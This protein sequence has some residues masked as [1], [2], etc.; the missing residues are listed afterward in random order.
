M[1]LLKVQKFK[2]VLAAQNAEG[3]ENSEGAEDV[4]AR[5]AAEGSESVQDAAHVKR[6]LSRWWSSESPGHVSWALG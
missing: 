6:K 5:Q 1:K 3:V 2:N 4:E